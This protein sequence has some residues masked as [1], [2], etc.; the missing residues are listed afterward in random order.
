MIFEDEVIPNEEGSPD[1][2]TDENQNTNDHGAKATS[3]SLRIGK[4]IEH[5]IAQ[6]LV[7]TKRRYH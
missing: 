6:I 2:I 4:K 3:F 1:D 5:K 7:T